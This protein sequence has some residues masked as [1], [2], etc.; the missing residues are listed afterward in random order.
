MKLGVNGLLW[1]T[2][3]GPEEIALLPRLRAAGFDLFEVPMFDPGTLPIASLRRALDNN[4]LDCTVCGILPQGLSPIHEDHA[5]RSR[6]VAHLKDCVK[7]A[8]DLGSKLIAGPLYAPVGYLCGRRRTVQE[9]QYAVDCFQ[10]LTSTLDENNVTLAI[11]PLN[12]FETFFLTTAEDAIR[13][14]DEVG[15]RRVGLLFDTFHTNIEEKDV[16][17]AFVSAG[18]RLKH[19]HIS[20]NDRGIPGT[21]HV[22]FPG[23]LNALPSIA[24]DGVLVIESFGYLLPEM[25]AATA[26]WRDLA[27]TPEAI[28]F[29]GLKYLRGIGADQAL[30]GR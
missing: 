9:W 22:D 10:D 23:I 4:E 14:C 19:I 30:P 7:A 13:L 24:Y 17:A 26:I 3:I 18:G 27:S 1:S 16:P 28:A 8:A 20:E 29:E 6:T 25:A 15:H 11:E 5:V 21:G 2:R 12:R